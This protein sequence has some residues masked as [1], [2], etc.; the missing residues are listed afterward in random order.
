MKNINRRE[1]IKKGS[2]VAI[3]TGVLMNTGFA[4][5]LLSLNK[6]K[7]VEVYDPNVVAEDR[8]VDRELVRKMLQDGLSEITGKKNKPLTKYIKPTDKVG[9]KINCLGRPF[10]FTHQELIDAMVLELKEIGVEENNI[11][12]WD[13]FPHHMIACKMDMNES[14]QGVRYM[15]TEDHFNKKYLNDEE[16]IY[17]SEV[18]NPERRYE[19]STDTFISR[20]LTQECDKIINMAILKDHGLAGVTLCLKN[21]SYGICNNNARFHGPE[22][23]STFISDIYSLPDVKDKVVLNIVDGLEACFEQGP[24]PRSNDVLFT[25][26][27]MWFSEDPVAIDSICHEVIEKE[28]EKNGLEAVADLRPGTEHILVAQEAGLGIADKN[29]IDLV[30]LEA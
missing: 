8:I 11:I 20:I 13:R 12:V 16:L 30:K 27:K 1:F 7:V 26:K 21:I 19:G 9:L 28:R 18:D 29:N 14:D 25:P 3:G 2:S 24:V 23:I 5:P 6:S 17:K 10:L 22:H 15:G 4:Y